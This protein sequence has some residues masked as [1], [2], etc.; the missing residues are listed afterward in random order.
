MK[1]GHKWSSDVSK[2]SMTGATLEWVNNIK[3]LGIMFTNGNRLH[4]DCNYIKWKFYTACNALLCKCKY[5]SKPVKLTLIK[6][7]CFPVLMY[8]LGV[9]QLPYYK[10]RELDVCWNDCFHRIFHYSRW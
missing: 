1:G 5:A 4:V 8:C 6:T 10:V 3:Y 7:S 9:L 2:M